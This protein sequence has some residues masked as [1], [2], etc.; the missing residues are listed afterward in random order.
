MISL[1][2]SSYQP[3]VFARFEK[4]VA[5]TCGCVYEIIR[6]ENPG[7][8]G[9]CAAYN[10]GA[11]KAVYDNLL[12]IHEDILFH[13]KNWG[14]K[15]V[16]HLTEEKAGAVGVV[17][18]DYV[19]KAPSGWYIN[20]MD[21]SFLY[22][23]QNNKNGDDPVFNNFV[24]EEKHPV[25]AIDGVF[26][27]INKIKFK[28][29]KF[30]DAL[31]GFHGYDTDFS[32]RVAK[33]YQNYVVTDI[34]IEHF[35]LGNSGKE[36]LTENIKVRNA[37]GSDFNKEKNKEIE[38][39]RFNE[40][41]NQFFSYYPVTFSRLLMTMKYFPFRILDWKDNKKLLKKYIKFLRYRNYFNDKLATKESADV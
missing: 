8:M 39:Q 1:I 28:E 34:L 17:G 40:F 6:I 19:P 38:Y 10:Q 41:L 37:V 15:L 35:S 24:H 32:L 30:N 21:H 20:N 11:N 12:F 7:L 3:E 27:A 22:L 29:F 18:S 13:T 25:F 36:W 2:I 9:I 31:T 16:K 14:E 33:K 26:I 23:I 5:E 4:N